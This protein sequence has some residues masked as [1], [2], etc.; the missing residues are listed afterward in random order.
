MTTIVWRFTDGKP[1]HD[2]QSQGLLCALC[3]RA[4]ILSHDIPVEQSGRSLWSWLS[5]ACRYDA[6][7]APPDLLIGAGHA[8]HWHLLAARRRWGGRT[9]VLMKPS[10]PLSWFD[11][12]LVPEHD[13]PLRAANVLSTLGSV[14]NIQAGG[15]R[16]VDSGLIILGGPSRHYR[17][18]D[19]QMLSQLERLIEKRPLK[20]WL[21]TTSRRTPQ[22]T[23]HALSDR[24]GLCFVPGAV[25]GADWLPARM[26]DAGEVWV[27]E[28]SVSMIYEAL[29]AGARLGLLQ[30]SRRR[31]ASRV[32]SGVDALVARGWVGSPGQWRL[33]AGPGQP[34]NEA[35]RCA[36]WINRQWLVKN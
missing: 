7:Y 31:A 5:G 25:T 22:S 15:D 13:G 23:L 29:T 8:T 20:R 28:D 3:K 32:A 21:I 10:L 4:D 30:V 1:G 14:N 11:L 9:I 35:A 19:D 34:I 6:R 2:S 33:A 18:N 17:W 36:E 27:S 24:P 16:D 26:A 12:C